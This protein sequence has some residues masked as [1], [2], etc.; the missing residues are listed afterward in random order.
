MNPF[1]PTEELAHVARVSEAR[2]VVAHE[3][4]VGSVK[5]AFSHL[6]PGTLKQ[7]WVL[8]RSREAAPLEQLMRHEPVSPVGLVSPMVKIRLRLI[9]GYGNICSYK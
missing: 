9:I 3:S 4:V 8:G 5:K 1:Q 2:Y 6:P 7:M